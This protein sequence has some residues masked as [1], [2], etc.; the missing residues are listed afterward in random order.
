M[1]GRRHEGARNEQ[2]GQQQMGKGMNA[3][4][5][6][7]K[8]SSDSKVSKV[9]QLERQTRGQ[10]LSSPCLQGRTHSTSGD[11][12]NKK[13]PGLAWRG[14]TLK[15]K[16]QRSVTALRAGQVILREVLAANVKPGPSEFAHVEPFR[17][18]KSHSI[19]PHA[20]KQVYNK[21]TRWSQRH[22]E[23][24]TLLAYEEE[25]TL[26]AYEEEDTLLACWSQRQHDIFLIFT[27]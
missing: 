22:E 19:K 2:M 23:E 18:V 15:A 25:D 3:L 14:S 10:D 16:F 20:R 12:G 11:D 4:P 7:P 5:D 6:G 17:V 1:H 26:L 21:R 8:A 24:D 13:A 9:D 27:S